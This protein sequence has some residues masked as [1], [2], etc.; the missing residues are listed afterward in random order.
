MGGEAMSKLE[1]SKLKGL[2]QQAANEQ[3]QRGSFSFDAAI[4]TV[5]A[6]NP[7]AIK[8]VSTLL[9]DATMHRYLSQIGERRPTVDDDQVEMS[10]AEY[11]GV[12]QWIPVGPSEF[13]L[14]T[15]ATLRQVNSWLVDDQ[16]R[17]STRRQRNP[18]TAK[19]VRDLSK[20]AG[21]MDITVADAMAL[22]PA[23][24]PKKAS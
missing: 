3:G 13:K 15:A 18:G 22:R 6:R 20:L 1:I 11:P 4:K 19:L 5:R 12:R 8:R 14:V 7:E 24:P 9:E 10:F 2:L 23:P 17:S 21:T 16:K